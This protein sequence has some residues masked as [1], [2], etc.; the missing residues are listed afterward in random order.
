MGRPYFGQPTAPLV[1][2]HLHDDGGAVDGDAIN[3]IQHGLLVEPEVEAKLV[4]RESVDPLGFCLRVPL[5]W[6]H[7]TS[8]VLTLYQDQFDAQTHDQVIIY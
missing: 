5:S 1:P 4:E 7:N 8:S 6:V 2:H 3:G